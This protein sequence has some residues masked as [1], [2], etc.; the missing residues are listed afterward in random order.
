MAANLPPDADVV[1]AA[2]ESNGSASDLGTQFWRAILPWDD[3]LAKS[4]PERWLQLQRDILP[5]LAV[6]VAGKSPTT[7]RLLSADATGRLLSASLGY[8]TDVTVDVAT[9]LTSQLLV[10]DGTIHTVG[11]WVTVP[12]VVG[13][14][15]AVGQVTGITPSSTGSSLGVQVAG[16]GGFWNNLP[17]GTVFLVIPPPPNYLTPSPWQGP[18]QVPILW[19]QAGIGTKSIIGAA[20]STRLWLHRMRWECTVAAAGSSVQLQD[21]TSGAVLDEFQ[22]TVTGQA[23]YAYGALPVTRGDGVQGVVSGGAATVRGVLYYSTAGN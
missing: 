23:D 12:A 22:T 19:T 2:A 5:V 8:F 13:N 7:A 11:E 15:L 17:A 6:L 21:A 20:A 4:P 3:L 14:G 18:N 10:A 9:G 16:T 1:A